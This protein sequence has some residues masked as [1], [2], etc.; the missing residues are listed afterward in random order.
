MWKTGKVKLEKRLVK[1]CTSVF[2][3][4]SVGLGVGGIGW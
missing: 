4:Q 3:M 1:I 2:K